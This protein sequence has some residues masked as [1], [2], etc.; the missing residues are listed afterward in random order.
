MIKKIEYLYLIKHPF[1]A[2][3]SRT[4]ILWRTSK[5]IKIINSIKCLNNRWNIIPSTFWTKNLSI[6]THIYMT[7]QQ[8]LKPPTSR[9][10]HRHNRKQLHR[11]S[12]TFWPEI[13]PYFISKSNESLIKKKDFFERFTYWKF[14]VLGNARKGFGNDQRLYQNMASRSHRR[15][16]TCSCFEDSFVLSKWNIYKYHTPLRMLIALI[17]TPMKLF[18]E[19]WL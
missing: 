5:P 15:I 14:S 8:S 7:I 9:S 11:V 13:S 6:W 1:E 18:L 16:K 3:C 12:R 10:L 19:V 17:S 2:N 4:F